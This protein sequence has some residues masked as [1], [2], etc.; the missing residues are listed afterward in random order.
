MKIATLLAALALVVGVQAAPG[1]KKAGDVIP[2]QF[3]VR[4]KPDVDQAAFTK[5]LKAE[6]ATENA[7][8]GVAVQS[9]VDHEFAVSAAFKG[10]AGT[11]SAGLAKRLKEH[12]KV[13]AV[14]QDTWVAISGV[15][16]SPPSWGLA[17]ISQRDLNLRGAPFVYPD[18]AGSGVN[19]YIIDT[20]VTV[21]HR[22]FG[23]RAS[24]GYVCSGCSQRDGQGHG[25][26]VAGTVAGATTGV[27]KRANVIAV[28]VL[29]DDGFGSNSEIINGVSW[30]AQHARQTGRRSV[31]NLSL[32]GGFSQATNDAVSALAAS[33]VFVG[34][35]AGN[36][37]QDACNVSPA[38]AAGAVCVAASTSN[39]ARASFSNYGQC[40]DIIAPGQDIYSAWNNG[41]YNTISGTS[42][43]TPMVVG[44]AA[45]TWS[46]NP[47]LSKDGLV[48]KLLNDATPNKI[49][50]VNGSPNRLLY[51][52]PQ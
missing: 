47:S 19:A 40:V 20:G 52:S 29:G 48:A 10:Y 28:K 11:F 35:A 15:Q 33:G 4:L 25:T 50:D 17:R 49:Y 34:V 9:K 8:E 18:A 23:G 3:I 41:G 36:E 27:A 31:A 7:R 21:N 5:A 12:P 6:V 2:N 37:S 13:A 45:A 16:Q 30:V 51:L 26:H 39:D 24:W 14:E 32:G 1:G 46:A 44:A 22:E 38:S 43:A 42:M